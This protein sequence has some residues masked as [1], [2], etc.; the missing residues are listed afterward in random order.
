METYIILVRY[1][2]ERSHESPD[3]DREALY[4]EL[5]LIYRRIY[6]ELFYVQ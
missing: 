2:D 4:E 3:H 5:R 1:M 6:Q